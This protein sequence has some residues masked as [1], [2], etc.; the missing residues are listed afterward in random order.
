MDDITEGMR[1]ADILA[2]HPQVNFVQRIV[3]PER[4]PRM[5]VGGGKSATH[6]MAWGEADGKAFVYPT[7]VEVAPGELVELS[8]QEAW[9]YA[10]KNNELI[11]FDNPKEA[12]WFSKRYKMFWK[13]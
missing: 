5:N 2:M 13:D 1:V 3:H 7:I 4:S 11:P 10:V 8:P 9:D 6:R 12:D